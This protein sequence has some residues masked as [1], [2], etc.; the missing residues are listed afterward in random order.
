MASFFKPSNLEDQMNRKVGAKNHI[1]FD[2]E[3]GIWT[4]DSFKGDSVSKDGAWPR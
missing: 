4:I 3:Y 1:L 2:S